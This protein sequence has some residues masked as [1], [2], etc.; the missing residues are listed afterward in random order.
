MIET[1]VLKKN[2]ILNISP[3][4]EDTVGST[5]LYST[6]GGNGT[7]GEYCERYNGVGYDEH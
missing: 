1:V 6:I 4:S 3:V 2:N 5:T 7:D